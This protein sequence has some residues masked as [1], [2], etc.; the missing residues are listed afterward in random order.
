LAAVNTTG[1][2]GSGFGS[3][4]GFAGA[5]KPLFATQTDK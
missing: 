5:G 1:F 3:N 2:G 4:Q